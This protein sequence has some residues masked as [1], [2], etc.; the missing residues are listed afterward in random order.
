[1]QCGIG[2]AKTGEG[3]FGKCVCVT[4]QGQVVDRALAA[5]RGF[6][7]PISCGRNSNRRGAGNSKSQ[8]SSSKWRADKRSRRE[9]NWWRNCQRHT[10]E[11]GCEKGWRSFSSLLWRRAHRHA[12]GGALRN[13]PS[14]YPAEVPSASSLAPETWHQRPPKP[15][16][17]ALAALHHVNPATVVCRRRFEKSGR[18]GGGTFVEQRLSHCNQTA[19]INNQTLLATRLPTR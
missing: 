15:L 17:R 2:Q 19:Q 12:T 7:P 8:D 13:R 1:M 3:G 4:N 14:D 6:L 9:S 11:R 18:F 5:H 10:A 16:A